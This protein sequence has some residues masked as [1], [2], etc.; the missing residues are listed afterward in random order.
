MKLG[1]NWKGKAGGIALMLTGT[2]AIIHG[3]VCGIENLSSGNLNQCTT[4]LYEGVLQ[5]AAG[6]GLFGI[7]EAIGKVSP[8]AAPEPP[9]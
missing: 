5:F 9:K 1:E 4:G 2:A 6:L 3:I 7:R 8:P